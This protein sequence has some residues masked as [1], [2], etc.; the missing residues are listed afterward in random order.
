MKLRFLYLLA[1]LLTVPLLVKSQIGGISASKL[2]T[3]CSSPVGTNTV[4][5]EPAFSS[6]FSK[7]IWDQDGELDEIYS[8]SEYDYITG[9]DFGFRLTYGAF[10]NFEIGLAFPVNF[11]S[12]DLGIKYE[13]LKRGDFSLAL[14][15]G[16]NLD[17]SARSVEKSSNP[18]FYSYGEGIVLSNNFTDNFGI[19][20]NAQIVQIP[21]D[22]A[23]TNMFLVNGD[24]GWYFHENY[25]FAVGLYYS[26]V[27]IEGA[28]KP[29][30][31]LEINPGFTIETGENFLFVLNFPLSLAGRNTFK[32]TAVQLALTITIE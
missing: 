9:S 10:Q 17:L 8:G 24:L 27:K 7:K 26:S 22:D 11:E 25:Q 2:G 21:S 5:F 23:I 4:E 30:Y 20:V 14:M 1:F 19:D 6:E 28:D 13:V 12:T 31:R 29:A 32:T 16:T 18:V 15:A 3:Y